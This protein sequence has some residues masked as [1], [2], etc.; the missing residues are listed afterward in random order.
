[1]DDIIKKRTSTNRE[2]GKYKLPEIEEKIH[3]PSCDNGIIQL[4]RTIY[5]L[6]DGD[7]IIIMSMECPKC[8][9]SR[10]DLIPLKSAFKPGKYFL[11]VDDGDLDHKI[12]RGTGGDIE[13]PEIGM[14]IE[15]GPAAQF[16][17]NN[18]EGL[19]MIME[20]RVNYFLET[21]PHNSREWMNANETLKRLKRCQA[22]EMKFTVILFDRSGGSYIIPTHPEKMHFI[23]QSES[24]DVL[25]QQ[26]N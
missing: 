15:R 11:N 21:T 4:N 5:H 26:E 18:V 17:I 8:K 23:P 12:F 25:E 24:E 6:P 20:D 19:L 16:M 3:C 1:M 2:D 9:F 13:I 14:S 10:N 22:R 7:D